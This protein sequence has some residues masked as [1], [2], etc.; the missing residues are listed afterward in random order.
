VVGDVAN[1]CIG[2]V[3]GARNVVANPAWPVTARQGTCHRGQI[4]RVLPP[5]RRGLSHTPLPSKGAV[6]N[7][8]HPRFPPSPG[9]G[10]VAA[11]PPST[12]DLGQQRLPRPTGNRVGHGRAGCA[13]RAPA[14]SCCTTEARDV[15]RAAMLRQCCRYDSSMMRDRLCHP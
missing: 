11:P 4:R 8:P 13:W 12:K 9:H 7:T 3:A 10:P 2:A 14:S 1:P 5:L 6:A 15:G